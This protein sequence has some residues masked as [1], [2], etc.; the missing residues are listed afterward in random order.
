MNGMLTGVA[1]GDQ[2]RVPGET[3]DPH[4]AADT[5]VDG[6]RPPRESAAHTHFGDADAAGIHLVTSL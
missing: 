5:I 1:Q 6:R 4:D 3:G 2:F